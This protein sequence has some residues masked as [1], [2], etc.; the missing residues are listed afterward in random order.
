VGQWLQSHGSKLADQGIA[1]DGKTLRGSADGDGKAV[2]LV[3]AVLHA[4]GTV[5]AQTRVPDKT[6]EIKSV[7]PLL[8][9]RDI[10]G[11]MVTGDAMFTQKDIAKYIVQDKQAD[12]LFTVKDNQPTL[13]QDIESLHLGDFPPRA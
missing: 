5:I 13:R 11:A 8:E 2:H 7:E 1:L 4:D 10:H 6:N 9:G 3:S 12:Y